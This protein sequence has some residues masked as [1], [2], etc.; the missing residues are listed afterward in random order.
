MYKK[1]FSFR[2]RPFKLVPNPEYYYVSRSHEEAMAHLSYAISEGD[3]FVEITGEVGTGKTT[4]CRVFLE[5]LDER[6]EVAYIFNPRLG[7]KQLLKTIADELGIRCQSN[8]IKNLIDALNVYLIR[9]KAEGRR[10]VLLVDEAQNLS[11]NVLEQLRLL[12]NLETSRSKLLQII[13]VGQPELGELLDSYDLRQLAQR[14]T[15]SCRLSPLTIREVREYIEH[16]IHVA[17]AKSQVPF[18]GSAVRLIYRYSKGVPR[19]IN[20]VC[21]R[22]LLTAYSRNRRKITGGVVRAAIR[23]LDA[24]RAAA[25][26][27]KKGFKLPLSVLA[28]V[29]FAILML[30]FYKQGTAGTQQFAERILGTAI[31]KVFPREESQLVIV[32][33]DRM[34][35]APAQTFESPQRLESDALSRFLVEMDVRSARHI[36]MTS[37]LELWGVETVLDPLLDDETDDDAFFKMAAEQNGFSMLK[38]ECNFGLLTSLNLPA[39]IAVRIPRDSPPGFL[40]LT[41]IDG[42]EVTLGRPGRNTVITVPEDELTASCHGPVYIPWRNHLDDDDQIRGGQPDA[43]VVRLKKYLREIGFSQVDTGPDYDDQ[44]EWAVQHLQEKNGLPPDGIVGPLTKILL[45]NENPALNIPHIRREVA[46]RQ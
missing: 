39:V 37:V 7:P 44:T 35:A 9:M 5:N 11:R 42:Q 26:R 32:Q 17:S 19:L 46:K 20:I 22:S 21:D 13:L 1:F 34:P 25:R 41:A 27:K 28:V 12:S 45:F 15:L 23:E 31:S 14:V 29:C 30:W 10:V 4:L 8:D 3:G 24:G 40:T 33:Q 18:S 16:R 38:T 2:E 43:S 36:A 6:T